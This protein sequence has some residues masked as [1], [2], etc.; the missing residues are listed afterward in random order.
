MWV[1]W[2]IERRDTRPLLQRRRHPLETL[3]GRVV[4]LSVS[5]ARIIAPTDPSLRV[6]STLVILAEGC[7][8]LVAIKQLAPTDEEGL[9][10][11][12]V[13]FVDFPDRFTQAVYARIEELSD[14]TRAH[15]ELWER[16]R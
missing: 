16:S 15:R 10:S 12:G 13:S 2:H 1:T 6:G 3:Y 14:P 4:D 11:Y 8:G 5:G 9:T 7:R